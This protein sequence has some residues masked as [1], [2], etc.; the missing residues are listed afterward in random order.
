MLCTRNSRRR[1]RHLAHKNAYNRLRMLEAL[2]P[3]LQMSAGIGIPDG[4]FTYSLEEL[5]DTNGDTRVTP[6]DA[7]RI[8]NHINQPTIST[9]DPISRLDVS[10]DG[11]L[12]SNDVTTVLETA[13]RNNPLSVR[14]NAEN[15]IPRPHGR[16]F[17]LKISS[18]S[19]T[20][21]DGASVVVSTLAEGESGGSGGSGGTNPAPVFNESGG[22]YFLTWN[23]REVHQPFTVHD[24]DL[25]SIQA[26]S[27]SLFTLSQV[28]ITDDG[29]NDGNPNDIDCV[30]GVLV[31]TPTMPLFGTYTSWITATS[32]DGKTDSFDV[33]IKTYN[34][35]SWEIREK[36]MGSVSADFQP[37]EDEP[38]MWGMNQ[39]KKYIETSPTDTLQLDGS[40]ES[41]SWYRM[42]WQTYNEA[43]PAFRADLANWTYG[44]P[45]SGDFMIFARV[46]YA[47]DDYWT[48][49]VHR[50]FLTDVTSVEWVGWG[51]DSGGV[52]DIA[53]QDGVSNLVVDPS[54]DFRFYQ[55]QNHPD[56]YI[57]GNGN[58]V[59]VQDHELHNR[60]DV[61][62]T[63]SPSMP[64]GLSGTLNLRSFDPDNSLPDGATDT[65]LDG[66]R[67]LYNA[68]CEIAYD[69]VSNYDFESVVTIAALTS[70]GEATVQFSGTGHPGDNYLVA[71][72]SDASFAGFRIDPFHPT[73][74]DYL[75]VNSVSNGSGGSGGTT[76]TWTDLP[77]N[78]HTPTLT[79]WRT[80]WTEGDSM[81]DPAT[82]SDDG[83]RGVFNDENSLV[84]DERFDPTPAPTGLLETEFARACIT[85]RDLPATY[86]THTEGYFEHNIRFANVQ[87]GRFAHVRDVTSYDDFW[88]AHLMACYEYEVPVDGDPNEEDAFLGMSLGSA[89]TFEETIRDLSQNRV[90]SVDRETLRT[91]TVVHEVL[92][93]FF[94]DHLRPA[95]NPDPG[96]NRQHNLANRGIMDTETNVFGNA[97]DNSLSLLQLSYL[98]R[99]TP[100]F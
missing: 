57:D 29:R 76:E 13:E 48:G 41:V 8:I 7:L 71:I 65:V 1:L 72:R 99:T 12:D 47:G 62:V 63:I 5:C 4:P 88:S 31:F 67:S 79:I 66:D 15:L 95:P 23:G 54:G 24:N 70:S 21:G 81:R 82:Q 18:A 55:E 35:N 16:I 80:L 27:S 14:Y 22:F 97:T 30:S 33:T 53:Y 38:I 37:L 96:D 61:R 25:A 49:S 90:G 34:I 40:V 86:N 98:Q 17:P 9:V 11:T 32:A 19:D 73:D 100:T 51:Q 20:T 89:V 69:N 3:R 59:Q 36:I 2:E 68:I 46:D 91:R 92:H 74:L 45:V 52:R 64:E 78:L 58:G 39:Y 44:F 6:I 83:M 94:G 93:R 50:V 75:T 56:A 84:D 87:P 85:V 60:V 42:D 10:G 26:S 77:G 43:S 28:I